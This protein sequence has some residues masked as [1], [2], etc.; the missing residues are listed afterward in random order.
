MREYT[1]DEFAQLCD[2]FDE[3]GWK[4]NNW[5]P[6]VKDIETVIAPRID[7]MLEF[8][9]WITETSEKPTTPEQQE[10]S[11]MLKKLANDNMNIV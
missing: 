7:E 8:V 1:F 3:I 10:S 5:W 4:N 9:L 2:S 6:S 11:R